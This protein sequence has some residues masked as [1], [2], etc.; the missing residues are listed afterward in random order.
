MSWLP[1]STE[2]CYA[3]L[4]QQQAMLLVFIMTHAPV[5]VGCFSFCKSMRSKPGGCHRGLRR[6]SD[7]AICLSATT[8]P[9]GPTSPKYLTA[10]VVVVPAS[11]NKVHCTRHRLQ[12]SSP[13]LLHH[14]PCLQQPAAC[15]LYLIYLQITHQAYVTRMRSE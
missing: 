2:R 11:E 8:H 9:P 10:S 6:S 13:A 4:G 3:N 1:L 14:Y 7:L 12:R 15:R 5:A